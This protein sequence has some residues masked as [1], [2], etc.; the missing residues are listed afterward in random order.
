LARNT[1]GWVLI[2][3]PYFSISQPWDRYIKNPTARQTILFMPE[4][5]LVYSKIGLGILVW[6]VTIKRHR[7]MPNSAAIVSTTMAHISAG[8]IVLHQQ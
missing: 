4:R 1:A 6:I 2:I 5:N 8:R 3:Q 7:Y